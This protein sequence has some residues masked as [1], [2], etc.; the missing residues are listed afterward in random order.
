M[1][2]GKIHPL[3]ILFFQPELKLPL[4]MTLDEVR[5]H[6]AKNKSPHV[7]LLQLNT[8]NLDQNENDDETTME[9]GQSSPKKAKVPPERLGRSPMMMYIGKLYREKK[10]D[11]EKGTRERKNT[12]PKALPPPHYD[13]WDLDFVPLQCSQCEFQATHEV[14]KQH[15]KDEHPE[16]FS[17]A[18]DLEARHKKKKYTVFICPC[19]GCVF[20]TYWQEVIDRHIKGHKNQRREL[21]G[22][23]FKVFGDKTPN[24]AGKHR[25]IVDFRRTV[26]RTVV[27]RR[28]GHC[29][30]KSFEHWTVRFFAK[31]KNGQA[32]GFQRPRG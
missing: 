16:L 1:R 12:R 21:E 23:I 13:H 19:T 28:F 27:S 7:Q 22:L 24:S 14:I 17:T 10:S 25:S 15:Y 18:F 26:Q 4:K 29:E 3:I 5:S 31:Y 8:N 9:E 11:G 32:R 2:Q 6:V 30:S 20:T